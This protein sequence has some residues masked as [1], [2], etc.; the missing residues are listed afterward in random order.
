MEQRHVFVYLTTLAKISYCEEMITKMKWTGIA[1]GLLVSGSLYALAV[2][3]VR[4][5][6]MITPIGG[7]FFIVGWVLLAMAAFRTTPE[8]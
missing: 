7:T 3:G 5:F 4:S 1:A 2:T 6:G 8:S